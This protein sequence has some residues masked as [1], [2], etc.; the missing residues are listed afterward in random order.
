MPQAHNPTS[1]IG[2]T[3]VLRSAAA[4]ADAFLINRAEQF[5]L[6]MERAREVA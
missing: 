2:R 5:T 6:R 4:D 1:L 3:I